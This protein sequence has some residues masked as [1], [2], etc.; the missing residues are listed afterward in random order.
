M[1]TAPETYQTQCQT[2]RGHSIKSFSLSSL[3]P[4]VIRQIYTEYL[5]GARHT[6]RHWRHSDEQ[7]R[8]GSATIPSAFSRISPSNLGQSVQRARGHQQHTCRHREGWQL[9]GETFFEDLRS[10]AKS[11]RAILLQACEQSCLPFGK[12]RAVQPTFLLSTNPFL[13]QRSVYRIQQFPVEH[14]F[15]TPPQ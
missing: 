13:S 9:N 11:W 3:I 14:R 12:Q 10:T 2:H 7:D 8:Q 1:T 4:S 15:C 5:L 6:A